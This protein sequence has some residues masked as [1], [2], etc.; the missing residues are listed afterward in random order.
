MDE[1]VPLAKN[2]SL[3]TIASFPKKN[4]GLLEARTL[5]I[6]KFCPLF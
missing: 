5:T 2:M 3:L 6:F 4:G 1:K